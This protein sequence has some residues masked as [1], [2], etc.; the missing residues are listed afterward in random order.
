[1][2]DIRRIVENAIGRDNARQYRTQV[3]QVCTALAR[4][5]DQSV[6]QLM[7]YGRDNGISEDQVRTALQQSGLLDM[8]Q[9]QDTGTG[10]DRLARLETT[11]NRLVE[12]AQQRL[13]IRI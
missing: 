4:E 5:L 11:V 13:G 1:M 10:D 9:P 2:P 3:D 7:Q 8:T 6:Q 12:V